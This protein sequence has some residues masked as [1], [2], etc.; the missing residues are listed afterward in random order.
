[1]TRA[2]CDHCIRCAEHLSGPE[3]MGKAE[4]HAVWVDDEGVTDGRVWLVCGACLGTGS[5]HGPGYAEVEAPFEPRHCHGCDAI[6]NPNE[7]ERVVH[8]GRCGDPR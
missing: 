1:M 7:P 6:I 8:C 5:Q 4:H 2:A 3:H